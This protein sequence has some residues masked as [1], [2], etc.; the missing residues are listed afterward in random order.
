[1]IDDAAAPEGD[2]TGAEATRCGPEIGD[3]T[4]VLELGAGSRIC[5][6]RTEPDT[7]RL[8]GNRSVV[9]DVPILSIRSTTPCSAQR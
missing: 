9:G 3:R 1:M 8:A 4:E 5:R 7:A 6:Q 2:D